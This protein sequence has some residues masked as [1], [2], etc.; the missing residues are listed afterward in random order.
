MREQ[1]KGTARTTITMIIPVE[2]PVPSALW[3]E[4]GGSSP[5]R[6]KPPELAVGRDAGGVM[7]GVGNECPALVQPLIKPVEKINM[8]VVGDKKNYHL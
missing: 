2:R 8:L 3:V 4:L 1:P 5:L 6:G 7:L